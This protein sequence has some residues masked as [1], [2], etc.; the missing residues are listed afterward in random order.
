MSN[1]EKLKFLRRRQSVSQRTKTEN[2][3]K[4]FRLKK[5]QL[6]WSIIVDI[7]KKR[8]QDD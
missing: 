7:E 1:E 4:K 3:M 6:L 5:K 2:R 8:E